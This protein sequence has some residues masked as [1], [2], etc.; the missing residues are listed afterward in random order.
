MYFHPAGKKFC[1]QLDSTRYDLKVLKQVLVYNLVFESI[2]IGSRESHIL[3][4]NSVPKYHYF[5]KTLNILQ[6]QQNTVI[7]SMGYGGWTSPPPLRGGAG[8]VGPNFDQLN[9][10][11][12]HQFLE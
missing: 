9:Q 8:G 1:S 3:I 10:S 7:H 6:L 12:F 4:Q 2:G 11:K 5:F